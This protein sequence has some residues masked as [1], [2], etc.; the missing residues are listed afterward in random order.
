MLWF[1]FRSL[2][3]IGGGV[4]E[5]GGWSGTQW[6]VRVGGVRGG[7]L[8]RWHSACGHAAEDFPPVPWW[9]LELNLVGG[10]ALLDKCLGAGFWSCQD[11]QALTPLGLPWRRGRRVTSW[12]RGV[13]FPG[14]AMGGGGGGMVTR[15]SS[16]LAL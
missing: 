10:E 2:A 5:G 7:P 14:P 4:G 11:L 9:F 13:L 12:L 15:R 3:G 16:L 1:S 6:R 8:V